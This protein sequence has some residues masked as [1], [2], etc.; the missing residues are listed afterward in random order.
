MYDKSIAMPAN[1]SSMLGGPGE[2]GAEMVSGGRAVAGQGGPSW[3]RG[4][5][6]SKIDG[7]LT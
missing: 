1:S 3:R 5:G 4:E 2:G 7:R 6:E